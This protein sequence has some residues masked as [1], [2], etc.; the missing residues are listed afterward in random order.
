MNRFLGLLRFGLGYW[1]TWLPGVALLACVGVL[2]TF[3]TLLFQP[4]FDQVLKPD[5]PEGPI[6]LGLHNSRWHFDL[7]SLIPH[8][9]HMHNAWDV[10]ACALVLSTIAKG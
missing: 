2:D 7:R 10:V 8:F 4:I 1:L 5:A 6:L 9:I 3:R